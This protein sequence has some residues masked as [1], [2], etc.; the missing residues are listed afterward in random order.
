M[1]DT[2][3]PPVDA[4]TAPATGTR[5][6]PEAVHRLIEY[7]RDCAWADGYRT[8]LLDVAAGAAELDATWRT[9]GRV[10]YARRVADRIA[11]FEQHAE[12]LAG[13]IGRA[14]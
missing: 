6:L 11:L 14:A 1:N 2:T 12:R 9:A 7:E 5:G 8:A 3:S 10:E 4:L 13:H